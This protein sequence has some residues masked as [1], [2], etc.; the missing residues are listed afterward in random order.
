MT[1]LVFSTDYMSLLSRTSNKSAVLVYI[2]FDTFKNDQGIV[3]ITYVE[4]EEHLAIASST[5]QKSLLILKRLEL[6]EEVED[7]SSN[8]KYRILSPKVLS[9]E[10]KE[11]IIKESKTEEYS[12]NTALRRKYTSD[13]IPI[14]FQQL[15]NKKTLQKIYKELGS[16]RNPKE[17]CKYLKIDYQ[18]F[19]LFAESTEEGS[20]RSRFEK[21]AKE[22][23]V[24]KEQSQISKE[25]TE[26]TTYLYDH[27]KSLGVKPSDSKWFLKNTNAAK[28]ILASITIEEAK[29]ALDWG[30][31]DKWWCDK[32]TNLSVI[33]S[34]RDR[35]ALQNRKSSGIKRTTLI[36][37]EIRAIIR[38]QNFTIE[39]NTYE[40]AYFLK[41]SIL[42]GQ[43]H[44]EIKRIVQILEENGI[45]PE[46]NNNLRFG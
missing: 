20:F 33:T 35:I 27:L 21:L 3:Q 2:L 46:G 6:I 7:Q 15:L 44:I 30:L 25:A 1:S 19:R 9:P 38:N 37:E 29:E 13:N 41:Q 17:I 28:T 43:V 39:V 31:A 5:I 11:E 12:I 8:K 32:I 45:I 10:L 36:P 24:K 22:I 16:L 26:L 40:D 4:L 23:E 18:T 14:E 42:D 34:I